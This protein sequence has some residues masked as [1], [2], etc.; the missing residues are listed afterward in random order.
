MELHL[1]I[2]GVCLIILGLAHALFPRQFNWKEELRSL[3]RINR[4]MM[5][6]H[7]FFIAVVLL[8]VGMLCL[9]SSTELIET[10]LGKRVSFGIGIFWI[11]RLYIQFFGYSSET[12]KGKPFETTAHILLSIFWAYLSVIFIMIY[13]Y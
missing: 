2:I 3:S 10:A 13:R 11:A 4:E 12:W 8:L 9:T 1:K 5:Y 7:A 6:V